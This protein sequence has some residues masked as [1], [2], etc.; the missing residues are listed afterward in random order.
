MLDPI[1]TPAPI[2]CPRCQGFGRI[3]RLHGRLVSRKC[4]DCGGSGV[5]G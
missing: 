3:W 4:P 1:P 2:I 5:K